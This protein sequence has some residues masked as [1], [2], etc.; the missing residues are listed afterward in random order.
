MFTCGCLILYYGYNHGLPYSYCASVLL[1][2][3]S[4]QRGSIAV[5]TRGDV[6]YYVL[7]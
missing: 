1:L 3:S 4:E 5:N 7:L 2:Y 6:I